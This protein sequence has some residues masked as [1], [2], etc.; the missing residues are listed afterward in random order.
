MQSIFLTVGFEV[1]RPKINSPGYSHQQSA[2]STRNE[3]RQIGLHVEVPPQLRYVA[4]RGISKS[5]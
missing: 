5:K 2:E 3:H 4:Y 1:H